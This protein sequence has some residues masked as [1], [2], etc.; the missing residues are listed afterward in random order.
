MLRKELFAMHPTSPLFLLLSALLLVPGYPYLVTFF[1]TGLAVFF[2]CLSGRENH[3]VV[4]SLSLPVSSADVVKARFAYVVL[5]E[6]AQWVLAIPF[7]FLRQ[8]MPVPENPV[9]MEA[10]LALLGLALGMMG[11]FN[12]VFL[13]RYYRDVNKVGASFGW[14]AGAVAVYML[15]VE[16]SAHV[17]PFVRDR[18]DTPDPQFLGE[19]LAVLALGAVLYAGLTLGT[20]KRAIKSFEQLDL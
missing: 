20:L 5:L 16:T 4:Y 17:V 3:D 7:A 6:L 18:L 14:A 1:Y 9:G 19:K 15:L 12:W 8:Q 13:G 2:T 10:N 11:V